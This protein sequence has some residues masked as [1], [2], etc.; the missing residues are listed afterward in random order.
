M[1]GNVLQLREL[2]T[3]DTGIRA[4]KTE[5]VIEFVHYQGEEHP[6]DSDELEEVGWWNKLCDVKPQLKWK[7]DHQLVMFRLYELVSPSSPLF[8]KMTPTRG[9]ECAG[10]YIHGRV[11]TSP[12]F[13][14]L[15][16]I[17]CH[18]DICSKEI[19]GKQKHFDTATLNFMHSHLPASPRLFGAWRQMAGTG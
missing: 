9:G 6:V 2:V 18:L 19:A 7:G 1:K 12:A 15:S 17:L 4:Y 8:I 16:S 14:P 11:F 5:L 13:N 3:E 10:I